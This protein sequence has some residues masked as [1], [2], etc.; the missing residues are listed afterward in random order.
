MYRFLL[1]PVWLLFHVVVVGA[2]V[3]MVMLGL[4]QLDR[5]DQRQDFN[6]LVIERSEQTPVPVDDVV[7]DLAA[8]RTTPDEVEWIPVVATGTFL[9]GQIVEYNQSQ[10]GRAGE[11]T[12]AALALDAGGVVIVNRGFLPLGFET[13]PAPEGEVRITGLLRTSD[14]RRRGGLTD[15]SAAD[16]V[17]TEVRRIDLDVLATRYPGEVAPVYLQLVRSE[18]PVGATDPEP[19][20]RP[21]L[22]SGP[23]LSYAIQWFVFALCVAIGWVLAVRRSLGSRRS[24]GD[25]TSRSDP[26]AVSSPTPGG[27]S[28]GSTSSDVLAS[29]VADPTPVR[30]AAGRRTP[31][32]HR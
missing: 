26:A 1:R 2:I 13:T 3:A 28:S 15:A 25:P 18:P 11:N 5:L 17:I 30:D 32:D 31:A 16:G 23:H 22:D 20:V 21:E 9:P 14:V 4:W 19:I 8:G 29:D 12:L 7:A 27:A 10:G 24:D 6:R